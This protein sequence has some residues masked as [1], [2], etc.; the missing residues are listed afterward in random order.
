MEFEFDFDFGF[1][2]E[3]APEHLHKQV[4]EVIEHPE[5]HVEIVVPIPWGRKVLFLDVA[6]K[7]VTVS[8]KPFFWRTNSQTY[9]F[10]AIA[11][12]AVTCDQVPGLKIFRPK[13]LAYGITFIDQ[14][15]QPLWHMTTWRTTEFK[16]LIEKFKVVFANE[17]EKG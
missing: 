15:K 14:D 17:I 4:I 6:N 5:G 16:S 9:P 12:I 10:K 13:T 1:D 3:D 7:L 8:K 2:L 11:Q